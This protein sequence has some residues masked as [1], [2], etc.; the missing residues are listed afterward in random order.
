D[1]FEEIVVGIEEE[2]KAGAELVDLQATAERPFDVLHAVV[3]RESQF[4]ERGG[5]RRANVVAA[6]RDR[7]K[8]GSKLRAELE[9]VD[10]QAH[11]RRRRIDVL[12]LGDVFLQNI[13]LDR[14]RYL[15]PVRA[16]LL[17]YD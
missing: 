16:L 15:L 4:L 12:L 9:G 14:A 7:I 3:H 17:G 11:A 10:Y 13:V 8:A 2:T 5:T 1:L 6:D